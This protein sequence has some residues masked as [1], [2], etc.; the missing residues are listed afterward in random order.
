MNAKNSEFG[1]GGINWI[2]I[3]DDDN[4]GKLPMITDVIVDNE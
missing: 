4:Y 2:S 3:S 1:Y